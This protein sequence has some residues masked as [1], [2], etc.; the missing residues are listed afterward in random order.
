MSRLLVDS[1]V[2]IKW[3]HTEGEGE[4]AES[5]VLR[6]S[7]Q[8]GEVEAYMLDLAVYEVG[9]VLV[10]ALHWGPSEAADQLEDLLSI[11]GT[12]LVMASEWLSIAAQLASSHRLTF[13]D[14]AWAAAA[15]GLG[16]PLVSS[17]RDLVVAGLAESPKAIVERLRLS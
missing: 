9:N 11:C 4:L 13:Y 17:D 15:Q 16:I 10:R 8:R 14:A 12:P 5:R 2:L 3:F 1:S 7:H 6:D